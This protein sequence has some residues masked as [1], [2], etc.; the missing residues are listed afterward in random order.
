VTV[1]F[2][3]DEKDIAAGHSISIRRSRATLQASHFERFRAT[4]AQTV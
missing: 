2:A 3:T 4:G 1:V